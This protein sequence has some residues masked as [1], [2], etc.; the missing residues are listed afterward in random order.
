MK[1]KK[2]IPKIK[3]KTKQITKLTKYAIFNSLGR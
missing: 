2:I 3:L 1:N